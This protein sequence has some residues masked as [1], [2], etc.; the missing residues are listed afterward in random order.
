MTDRD[1]KRL[2]GVHPIMVAK[3]E[4]ILDSMGMFVVVGIRTQAEQAIDYLKGR[5]GGPVGSSIVTNCD[6]VKF[7]S[8]HQVR[9]DGFG[10]AVDCAFNGPNPY[11]AGQPW[12]KFGEAL[13][14]AGLRW[15]G[16]FS[17]PI[18]LDHAETL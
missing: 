14:A 4:P 7:K 10:H 1:R 9:S 6:G 8:P 18:D 3:L 17:H 15:G 11:G 12:E 13:E 5:P 16:R 2:E